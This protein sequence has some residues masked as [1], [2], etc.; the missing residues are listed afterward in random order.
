MRRSEICEAMGYLSHPL[1]AMYYDV[2]VPPKKRA[3]FEAGYRKWTG[4]S[5]CS[6]GTSGYSILGESVDKYAVQYRISYRPVGRVPPFVRSVSKSGSSG[7][8]RISRKALLLAMF[9][10]GFLMGSMPS[11]D[12]IVSRIDA[13]CH[14]HFE[15]GY[16]AAFSD[17]EHLN[18]KKFSAGFFAVDDISQGEFSLYDEQASKPVY[19]VRKG[20]SAAFRHHVLRV[21]NNQCCV[22][23]GSLVDLT[24]VYETE[25]AHIVPKSCAGSD[26]IR[27]GLALCRKHHWSFDRGM[28]WIDDDYRVNVPQEILAI[29]ENT[30]LGEYNGSEIYY[31]PEP[32]MAPHHAAL[33]WHK[34][35]ILPMFSMGS[36]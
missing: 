3:E 32:N 36:E 21:Y 30:S 26:D 4:T 33:V 29:E 6:P 20:R 14:V 2:Q 35:N 22:C 15:F 34:E 5:A 9:N 24:G 23:S 19:S 25:A 8:M 17:R 1:V 13:S 16:A 27:N 12:R 11:R 28:F 18:F 7:R 31:S 10:S